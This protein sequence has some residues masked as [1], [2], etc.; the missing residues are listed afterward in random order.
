MSAASKSKM[1]RFILADLGREAL[2]NKVANDL[3]QQRQSNASARGA[4]LKEPLRN[5][6]KSIWKRFRKATVI[7]ST[8]GRS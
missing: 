8:L 3:P 6:C 4:S 2:K 5:L 1:P 7:R